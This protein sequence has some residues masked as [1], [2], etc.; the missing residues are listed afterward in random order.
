[1]RTEIG[2][3]VQT[4]VE[5]TLVPLS[6]GWSLSVAVS[7]VVWLLFA[8]LHV[9]A[10]LSPTTTPEVKADAYVGMASAF[11]FAILIVFQP[12]LVTTKCE[13]IERELNELRTRGTGSGQGMV[14]VTTN[15]HVVIIET[16]LSK[17]NKGQ[18][19]GF[20]LFGKVVSKAVLVTVASK[21]VGYSSLLIQALTS[22]QIGDIH[23][24][25]VPDDDPAAALAGLPSG[26]YNLTVSNSSI[27]ITDP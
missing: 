20:V 12:A 24:A 4:L 13:K 17:L 25:T 14:D 6:E 16:F 27:T 22:L 3:D 2:P 18:G 10:V 21:V 9:P 23:D 7:V 8:G 19:P 5:E 26:S 1:L 15:D 11:I